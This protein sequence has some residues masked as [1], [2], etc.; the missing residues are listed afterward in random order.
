M[1]ATIGSPI[2]VV[3]VRPRPEMSVLSLRILE[4]IARTVAHVL[5]A[6][7]RDMRRY[8]SVVDPRDVEDKLDT[9][10][11]RIPKLRCA[12][13]TNDRTAL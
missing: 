6:G 11:A 1:N 3:E 12:I 9:A 7:K 5:T 13:P 2:D 10:V 4:L 8:A